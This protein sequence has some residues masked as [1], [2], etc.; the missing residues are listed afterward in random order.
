MTAL[1]CFSFQHAT[2][3]RP[4][5]ES[6]LESLRERLKG[7]NG[8]DNKTQEMLRLKREHWGKE[9]KVGEKIGRGMKEGSSK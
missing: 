4:E 7:S 2:N 1:F 3:G 5:L 9:D 6:G 8:K